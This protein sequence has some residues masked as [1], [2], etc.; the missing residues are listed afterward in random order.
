MYLDALP[1]SLVAQLWLLAAQ[2]LHLVAVLWLLVANIW[3]LVAILMFQIIHTM[4]PAIS[5]RY[6]AIPAAATDLPTKVNDCSSGLQGKP[7]GFREKS[8]RLPAVG[9]YFSRKP[10]LPETVI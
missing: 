1:I 3:L 10:C 8:P 5:C 4:L 2:F 9:L 6:N 7:F